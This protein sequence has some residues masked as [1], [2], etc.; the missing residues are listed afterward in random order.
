M[1]TLTYQTKHFQSERMQQRGVPVEFPE[2][3]RLFGKVTM[4]DATT[5]CVYFS[6]KSL[7]LMKK[8]G[9]AKRLILEVE[10][11]QDIRFIV[12][13][14]NGAFITVEYPYEANRRFKRDTKSFNRTKELH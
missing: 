3:A 8:A 11:R 14:E 6:N 13:K 4:R 10:D 5:N 12:S 1:Q 2:L 9:V 7:S